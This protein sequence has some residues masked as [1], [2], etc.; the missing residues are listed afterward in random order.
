MTGDRRQA[1]SMTIDGGALIQAEVQPE[2]S[3]HLDG[4]VSK[5]EHASFGIVK[6]LEAMQR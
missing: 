3:L 6:V 5:D 4:N 2:S 1:S